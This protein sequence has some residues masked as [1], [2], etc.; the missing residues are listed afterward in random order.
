M[1]DAVSLLRNFH[2][3]QSQSIATAGEG[4]VPADPGGAEGAGDGK[5]SQSADCPTMSGASCHSPL[6]RDANI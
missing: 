5:A 3:H 2:L 1:T 6:S 4:K